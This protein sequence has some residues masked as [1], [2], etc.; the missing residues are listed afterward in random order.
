RVGALTRAA[1]LLGL[2]IFPLAIGLG[3]VATTLTRAFLAP[4]WWMVGPMLAILSG[5]AVVRPL[6]GAVLSYLQVGLKFRAV[7]LVEWATVAFILGALF[8][9]GRISP[10]W[11]CTAIGI[12]FTARL[13]VS[14]EVLRRLERV[15]VMPILL[16][17]IG[18]LVA[19]LPMIAAAWGVHRG[20]VVLGRGQVHGVRAVPA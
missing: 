5:L 1:G 13:V 4:E 3:V 18:P 14:L 6:T 8:T 12:A 2:I 16:R 20:F 7:M 19:T 11:A 10:L 9:I 15:P 17:Q